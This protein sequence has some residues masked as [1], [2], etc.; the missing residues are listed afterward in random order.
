MVLSYSGVNSLTNTPGG[1]QAI[2]RQRGVFA[3]G[4]EILKYESIAILFIRF[5]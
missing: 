1:W 4:I 3:P 2:K 5:K